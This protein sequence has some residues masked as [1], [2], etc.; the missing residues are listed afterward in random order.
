[1]GRG[2]S[3]AIILPCRL[4]CNSR[5]F[6][7][8]NF[9]GSKEESGIGAV[10]VAIAVYLHVR[11]CGSAAYHARANAASIREIVVYDLEPRSRSAGDGHG[12]VEGYGAGATVLIPYDAY[13][14]RVRGHAENVIGIGGLLARVID[15]VVGKIGVQRSIGDS[16]CALLDGSNRI[17]AYVSVGRACSDS[18]ANLGSR[19]VAIQ[20]MEL[21]SGVELQA[22]AGRH[23]LARYLVEIGPPRESK[24]G[25]IVRPKSVA[26]VNRLAARGIIIEFGLSDLHRI[27]GSIN[28]H[29]RISERRS[30]NKLLYRKALD[31]RGG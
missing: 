31:G 12:V 22:S 29:S 24:R 17:V 30:A 23:A 5:S 6:T 16:E 28:H 8:A 14:R 20:V 11:P 2:I 7:K 9:S 26:E 15:G 1:M 25:Y 3:S 27:H 10:K 4:V 21:P 18:R 19:D 13:V